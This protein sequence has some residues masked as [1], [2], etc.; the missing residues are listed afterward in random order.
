MAKPSL[1]NLHILIL[2]LLNG[3]KISCPQQ[4]LDTEALSQSE[5]FCE[6]KDRRLKFTHPP[7]L[8]VDH[9]ENFEL[10]FSQAP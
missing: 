6:R 10:L 1:M 7:V 3:H 5:T 2:I 8:L 4:Q 9:C